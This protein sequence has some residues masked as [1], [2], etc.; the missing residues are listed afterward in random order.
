M[1]RSLYGKIIAD[2]DRIL[3]PDTILLR[4]VQYGLV[5]FPLLNPEEQ[6]ERVLQHVMNKYGENGYMTLWIDTP[7]NVGRLD[8]IRTMLRSEDEV[9]KRCWQILHSI[10]Q[11]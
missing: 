7:F 10:Y 3:F 4:T 9:K 6:I 5:H 8:A 1:P 2:A 11:S